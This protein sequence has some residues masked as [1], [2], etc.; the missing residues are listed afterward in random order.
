MITSSMLPQANTPAYFSFPSNQS[1]ETTHKHPQIN[2][3]ESNKFYLYFCNP[4]QSATSIILP[5]EKSNSLKVAPL[6][7]TVPTYEFSTF[8]IKSDT[9]SLSTFG[10]PIYVP[11]KIIYPQSL[12]TKDSNSINNSEAV[13]SQFLHSPDTR[14]FTNVE[15]LKFKDGYDSNAFALMQSKNVLQTSATFCREHAIVCLII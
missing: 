9:N 15:P 6:I 5:N 3:H 14:E 8:K 10:T 12:G 11:T 2:K 4:E 1:I 13:V 7:N